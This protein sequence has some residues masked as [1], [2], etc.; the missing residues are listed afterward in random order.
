[1]A[2]SIDTLLRWATTKSFQI[3]PDYGLAQMAEV[4]LKAEA[5]ADAISKPS[6]IAVDIFY[7]GTA[8]GSLDD[9]QGFAAKG[10]IARLS[11]NGVMTEQDG[12]CN[13]GMQTYANKLYDLYNDDR[14]AGVLLSV[15]SGGGEATA[16]D[17]LLNAIADKNKPVIVHTTFLGSA[18]LK[19]TLPATH[20][21]AASPS[22]EIG[23]IGAMISINKDTIEN[24]KTNFLELYATTSPDKNK[25]LRALLNDDPEA[26]VQRLNKLDAVFMEQVKQY[27]KL[28]PAT[29]EETL[30]GGIFTAQDAVNRGLIDSIGTFS[31]ALSLFKNS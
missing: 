8:K 26:M 27:R 25:E 4:L 16:G 11:I 12:L 30:S 24:I 1:M 15:S 28:D 19:G 18:A 9:L 6:S 31:T 22:T 23:S 21:M 20:I 17:V 29:M 5:S 7:N 10:S 14:I 3:V 2:V 13:Y